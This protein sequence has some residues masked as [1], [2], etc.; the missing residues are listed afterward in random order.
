MK[1]TVKDLVGL[2]GK[3]VLLRVDFNVPIDDAGRILDL[4]RINNALPTIKYLSS[5]GARVVILS[6]LDRPKGYDVRK[7]LWPIAV[8][9]M[10]KLSCSVS[11][12]NSVV[13]DETRE[14]IKA[15]KDGN[16]LILENV[17]FYE[18]ETTCDKQYSKE[19]AS[20]GEIFV[21]DAFGVAHRENASNYGV[22]RLLP[23][24]IGLLMEKE[25]N[26]LSSAM[27]NP[28]K[29]FVAILG[30]AKVQ[31]KISILYKFIEKADTIIV[32]G[33]MAYTFLYAMGQNIGT[34]ICHPESVEVAKGIIEKAK[35]EGKKLLLPVDHLVVRDT[36][37][38]RRAF[39]TDKM[40][41]DM[42]GYDIGPK[43][44]GLYAKEIATAGQIFWNGPMGMFENPEYKQGT[45]AVAKA[46]ASSKAYSIV[47]GGDTVNAVND[48]GLANKINYLSTG[49]GATLKFLEKGSLPA[50]EVIQEKI[51]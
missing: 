40:T 36:D 9:L 18:G 14:R 41:G 4:T 25:V 38:S 15:L 12:C 46:I 47:G 45:L 22:A 44:M 7:S 8:M 5:Q 31:T 32:G 43:T 10:R 20:L 30:G 16:V 39:Y 28:K 33:A 6:H 3:V 1:R 24:A 13:S 48:F 37:K 23:N 35:Q 19:I 26:E 42:A 21:N 34:S 11:F 27:E 29:P 17:R 2:K 50:L 49:G 51:Q